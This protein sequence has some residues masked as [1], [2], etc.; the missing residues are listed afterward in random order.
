MKRYPQNAH[1]PRNVYQERHGF[2]VRAM[3]R[4]Q[5]RVSAAFQTV[6]QAVA[7]RDRFVDLPQPRM[8]CPTC[9]HCLYGSKEEPVPAPPSSHHRGTESN[10]G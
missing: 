9:G 4:G 1:L 8:L 5:R 7:W 10:D 2:V 6:A 3:R